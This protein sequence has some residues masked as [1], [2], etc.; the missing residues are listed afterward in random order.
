MSA[1]PEDSDDVA[2]R[3]GFPQWRSVRW[4]T[5]R[6]QRSSPLWWL[7]LALALSATACSRKVQFDPAAMYEDAQLKL[8]RGEVEQARV[9]AERGLQR[10]PAAENDWHWRFRI[11]K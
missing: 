4:R 7:I 1:R 11:L 9:E 2:R 10:Y 5:G 3:I 8:K 6:Q